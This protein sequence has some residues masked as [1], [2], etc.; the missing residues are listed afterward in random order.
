[1][2]GQPDFP[3]ATCTDFPD[4][5]YYT[6]KNIPFARENSKTIFEPVGVS[7]ESHAL[8]GLNSECD[9][10]SGISDD[11][12]D[13]LVRGASELL[14]RFPDALPEYRSVVRNVMSQAEKPLSDQTPELVWPWD[15]LSPSVRTVLH[16]CLGESVSPGFLAPF[17][18]LLAVFPARGGEVIGDSIFSSM[19]RVLPLS[20]GSAEMLLTMRILQRPEN[21]S[22]GRRKK[23]WR[24]CAAI[25]TVSSGRIPKDIEPE[26]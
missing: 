14:E 18:D 12:R 9:I 11:Y 5:T 8:S 22:A 19:C 23:R 25:R 1:M 7:G 2:T 6:W 15:P 13:D 24:T 4:E 3:A 20:S 26:T 17:S 21:C 10:L 16:E